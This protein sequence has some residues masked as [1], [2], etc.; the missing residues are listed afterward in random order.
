MG[1]AAGIHMLNGAAVRVPVGD[2]KA[3]L[4]AGYEHPWG[5]ARWARAGSHPGDLQ[6]ILTHTPDNIHALEGRGFDAVFAGHYHGGQ[7]CI[8]ASAPWSCR[9]S[10]VVDTTVVTFCSG[11][12]TCSSPRALA[13]PS[14]PYASGASPTC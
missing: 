8:P 1:Q 7:I 2:G 4:V 14:R 5:S 13:Q 3:V 10:T 12:L 6:L 9:R 11:A